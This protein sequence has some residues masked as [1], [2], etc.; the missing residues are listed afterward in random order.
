MRSP[1]PG[2]AGWPT[3]LWMAGGGLSIA[4]GIWPEIGALMIA[5][6]AIPAA[7]WFPRF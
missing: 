7:G 4:V 1:I 5:A 2:L 6:F 3:G